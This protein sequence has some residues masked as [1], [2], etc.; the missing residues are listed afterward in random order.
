VGGSSPA[1]GP[2]PAGNGEFMAGEIAGVVAPTDDRQ[3]FPS[4]SGS[5]SCHSL[6]VKAIAGV[7]FFMTT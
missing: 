4:S 5:G 7:P 2:V 6:L 3:P 1:S